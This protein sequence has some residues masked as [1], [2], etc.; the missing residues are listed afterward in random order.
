M[1]TLE[2]ESLLL[3]LY[4]MER[5]NKERKLMGQYKTIFHFMVI[6]PVKCL[7]KQ[8]KSSLLFIIY[9]VIRSQQQT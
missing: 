6:A 1:S 2:Q 9:V 8:K 5:K 3:T 4:F 7:N